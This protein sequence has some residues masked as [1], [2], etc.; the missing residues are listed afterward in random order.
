[1]LVGFFLKYGVTKKNMSSIVAPGF[2]LT[3]VFRSRRSSMPPI[4]LSPMMSVVPFFH[5]ACGGSAS[6]YTLSRVH[7]FIEIEIDM[8]ISSS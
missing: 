6:L 2:G 3:F 7:S 5:Y 1:M 4:I 8:S